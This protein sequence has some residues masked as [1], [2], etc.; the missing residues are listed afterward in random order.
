MSIWT[1]SGFTGGGTYLQYIAISG[2]TAVAC[3][4]TNLYRS[5]NSGANWGQQES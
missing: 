2:A 4:G 1:S 3:D 5:T